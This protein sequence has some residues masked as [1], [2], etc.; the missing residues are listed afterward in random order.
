[1]AHVVEV[2]TLGV[3]VVHYREAVVLLLAVFH[4]IQHFVAGRRGT[5]NEGVTWFFMG[6]FERN[7]SI[8]VRSCMKRY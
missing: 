4:A 1:M 5:Q 2:A 6:I 3:T 7:F 8:P